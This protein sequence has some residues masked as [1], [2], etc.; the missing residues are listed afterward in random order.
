MTSILQLQTTGSFLKWSTC[1]TPHMVHVR[2]CVHGHCLLPHS[3]KKTMSAMPNDVTG[4]QNDQ[5][6]VLD[7]PQSQLIT[8]GNPPVFFI[9]FHPGVT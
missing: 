2:N 6:D 5:T 4:S 8:R 1:A 7:L 9:P 3:K